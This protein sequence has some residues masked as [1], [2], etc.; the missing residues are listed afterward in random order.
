MSK[1]MPTILYDYWRSSASY[2]VRIALETLGLPYKA[3]AV[4]L[5][6]RE[7]TAPAHL[8]RNPQGF[9]PV[10]EIDG[11]CLTQSTAII[12][13][14]DE[15][16]GAGF[17]PTDSAGR[18]RVRALANVIAMET[19]PVCNPHVVAH[20]LELAKG[21]DKM[22]ND[23]MK[24]FITKGLSAFEALL[25]NPATGRFC[26]GDEPGLADF[27]LVPQV[28]NAIRWGAGISGLHRVNEITAH[29]RDIAAFIRAHPDTVNPDA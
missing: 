18:A 13:Y 11:L 16:R 27:C 19:H 1:A 22:R 2:R 12:E 28:Y 14:L 9:V 10:L 24:H 8:A 21:D 17:L 4:D 23:W 3:V 20:V 29:C 7:H 25:D 15:T 6:K 26:H 5:L